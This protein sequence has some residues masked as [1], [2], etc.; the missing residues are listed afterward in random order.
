[1][2]GNDPQ[3]TASAV[4]DVARSKRMTE[5]AKTSSL[6]RQAHYNALSESGNPTQ[7]TL[8]AVL[9]AL[10]LELTVQKRAS[11][12]YGAC[13]PRYTPPCAVSCFAEPS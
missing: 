11:Q 9:G 8:V 13:L 7:E 4:G 5:L 1:M 3:H 2:V 6:G 10:A 12:P